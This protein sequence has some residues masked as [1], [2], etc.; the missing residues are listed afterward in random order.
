MISHSG[1]CSFGFLD[2]LF[3]GRALVHGG[4]AR[5]SGDG[6]LGRLGSTDWQGYGW[7]SGWET[8][9]SIRS[10]YDGH[11]YITSRFRSKRFETEQGWDG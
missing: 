6:V 2:L 5:E 10:W 7:R 8:A 3:R 1:V 11:L 9:L 4:H